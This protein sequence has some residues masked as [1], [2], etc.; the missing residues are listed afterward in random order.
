MIFITALNR[1]QK[2]HYDLIAA[3]KKSGFNNHYANVIA[4]EY[5]YSL[6]H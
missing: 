4:K 3:N 2:E 6:F 1:L 5:L